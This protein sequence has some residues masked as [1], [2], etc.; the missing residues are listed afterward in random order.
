MQEEKLPEFGVYS[1]FEVEL[2]KR[3]TYVRGWFLR[4]VVSALVLLRVHPD[5]V[6]FAGWLVAFAMYLSAGRVSD[7]A[8]GGLLI[9]YI[10]CD[11]LDGALA[12]C[13][14]KSD[15]GQ[16]VDN[17][18]DLVA[19]AM[20]LLTIWKLDWTPLPWL[21]VFMSFYI[22][23]LVGGFLAKYNG[24]DVLILRV[25]ILVFAAFF[26]VVFGGLAHSILLYA[27]GLGL[28]LQLLSILSIYAQLAVNFR[29]LRRPRL[30]SRLPMTTLTLGVLAL[31]AELIIGLLILTGS[32]S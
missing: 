23:I 8:L 21:L 26:G 10:L 6:S 24:L 13:H 28:F 2:K 20:I 30:F 7:E 27:L 22:V 25:R 17:F 31:V 11:N 4:P 1:S 3:Y 12:E 32:P 19:L 9:L 5:W 29:K 16:I 18:F 14:G 15:A